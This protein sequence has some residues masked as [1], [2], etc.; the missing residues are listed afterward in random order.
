MTG[1]KDK[2]DLSL[3][4]EKLVTIRSTTLPGNIWEMAITERK[5]DGSFSVTVGTRK[6]VY[7]YRV[8]YDL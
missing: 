8:K 5:E 2:K 6:G 1:Y 3:L 7:F 4:G